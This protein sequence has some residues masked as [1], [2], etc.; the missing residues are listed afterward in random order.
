VTEENGQNEDGGDQGSIDDLPNDPGLGFGLGARRSPGASL[1][2]G[3]PRVVYHPSK[4]T[5]LEDDDPDPDSTIPPMAIWVMKYRRHQ[6]LHRD[7]PDSSRGQLGTGD[8]VVYTLTDGDDHLMVC[9][10]VGVDPRGAEYYLVGRMEVG[11]HL[12]YTAGERPLVGCFADTRELALCSVFAD[13]GGVS[14]AAVVENYRKVKEVPAE[15]LP[16]SPFLEFSDD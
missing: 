2:Y 1:L 11:D 8:E 12:C 4:S 7:E 10:R 13:L 6:R 5:S 15:Y 3:S 14:N 16:P 9:R